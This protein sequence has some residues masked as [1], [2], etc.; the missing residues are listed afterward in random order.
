M[1]GAYP[2]KMAPIEITK[3]LK[4]SHKLILGWGLSDISAMVNSSLVCLLDQSSMDL[5]GT[6][7]RR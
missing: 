6:I 7:I 2:Q 4:K 3:T 1:F 5:S